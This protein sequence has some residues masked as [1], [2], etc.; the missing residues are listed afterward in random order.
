M[1]VDYP[2]VLADVEKRVLRMLGMSGQ[3]S[4][5]DPDDLVDWYNEAAWEFQLVTYYHRERKDLTFASGVVLLDLDEP[6]IETVKLIAVKEAGAPQDITDYETLKRLENA[7]ATNP[8]SRKWYA[9]NHYPEYVSAE[10]LG[11]VEFVSYPQLSGSAEVFWA[12]LAPRATDLDSDVYYPIQA[13]AHGVAARAAVVHKP[14]VVNYH[15]GKFLVMAQMIAGN[16]S[17]PGSAQL[18]GVGGFLESRS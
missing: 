18:A 3:S 15:E 12:Q 7:S 9:V 16:L 2:F 14:T 11:D 5:L 17:V 4:I 6:A 1:A 13:M 10:N 8:R